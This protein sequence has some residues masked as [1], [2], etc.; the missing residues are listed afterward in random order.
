MDRHAL[1]FARIGHRLEAVHLA[2][3]AFGRIPGTGQLYTGYQQRLTA[4]Q[5]GLDSAADG[6]AGIGAGLE[7]VR[8]GYESGDQ[9][10]AAGFR[11]IGGQLGG[12]R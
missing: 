9:R 5:D 8:V 10:S 2:A 7:G 3:G 11:S 1:A 12:D 6:L 4:A